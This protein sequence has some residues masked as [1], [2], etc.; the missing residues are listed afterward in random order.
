MSPWQASRNPKG[1][2]E[3]NPHKWNTQAP[4]GRPQNQPQAPPRVTTPQQKPQSEVGHQKR[5]GKSEENPAPRKRQRKAKERF[6]LEE[7]HSRKAHPGTGRLDRPHPRH[8]LRS[9]TSHIE[10]GT[11]SAMGETDS[12]VGEG[13]WREIQAQLWKRVSGTGLAIRKR[14]GV[15]GLPISIKTPLSPADH[16]VTYLS[17][18]CAL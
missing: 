3:P 11:G 1:Q 14:G 15:C 9:P 4:Q 6:S 12:V 17:F 5:Q 7:V 18:F 10:E 8:R 2:P 16:F 13:E